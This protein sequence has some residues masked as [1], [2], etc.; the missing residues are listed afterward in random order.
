MHRAK[1]AGLVGNLE[2]ST[3]QRG[4][5]RDVGH[6]CPFIVA[7]I[8]ADDQARTNLGSQTEVDHP[9]LPAPR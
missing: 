4:C 2:A 9:D 3:A 8:R 7:K 6:H 5:P 1:S